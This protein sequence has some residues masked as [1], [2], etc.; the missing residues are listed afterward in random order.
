VRRTLRLSSVVLQDRIRRCRSARAAAAAAAASALHDRADASD[1]GHRISAASLRRSSTKLGDSAGGSTEDLAPPV[2]RPL[3]GRR[4]PR[5]VDAA[6]QRLILEK[7]LEATMSEAERNARNLTAARLD[8][9]LDK[10]NR[11]L[12]V[13]RRGFHPP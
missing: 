3:S 4:V 9:L 5:A 11:T 2:D 12:T 6:R 8:E 13:K 7:L 10:D 1:F